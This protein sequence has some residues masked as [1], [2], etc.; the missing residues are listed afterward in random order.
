M[1]MISFEFRTSVGGLSFSKAPTL[2]R[3]RAE[4]LCGLHGWWNEERSFAV[5]FFRN[6]V[7]VLWT[8]LFSLSSIFF[9][10]FQFIF[11]CFKLKVLYFSLLPGLRGYCPEPKQKRR[12]GK[13]NSSISI[14]NLHRMDLNR[15]YFLFSHR[16]CNDLSSGHNKIT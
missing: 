6:F 5:P 8:E 1:L 2:H 11:V 14:S 12:I 13:G 15:D 16:E 7:S 3:N 10:F 4:F 9:F